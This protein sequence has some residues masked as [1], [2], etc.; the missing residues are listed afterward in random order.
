[1]SSPAKALQHLWGLIAGRECY[2]VW[3]C[4]GIGQA[5]LPDTLSRSP[6]TLIRVIPSG[7]PPAENPVLHLLWE[8][9]PLVGDAPR[10]SS[11]L[12]LGPNQNK[13]APRRIETKRFDGLLFGGATPEKT[14]C[15]SSAESS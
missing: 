3:L 14:F 1:M 13:E 4:A 9:L 12:R 7:P 8:R 2:P 10:K 5:H 6:S 15:F 11:N